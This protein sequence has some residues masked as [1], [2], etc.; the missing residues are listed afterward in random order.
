M[1]LRKKYHYF[2]KRCVFLE[3]RSETSCLRD[4]TMLVF[5]ASLAKKL[6]IDVKSNV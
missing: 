6:E 3:N 5:M 4:V 1:E 2:I